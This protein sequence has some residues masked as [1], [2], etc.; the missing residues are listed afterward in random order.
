MAFGVL[1]L[2]KTKNLIIKKKRTHFLK[3]THKR[4]F[5]FGIHR[6]GIGPMLRQRSGDVDSR[7]V[8]EHP[9]KQPQHWS[10]QLGGSLPT[11]GNFSPLRRIEDSADDE[12]TTSGK[13][14]STLH[15]YHLIIISFFQKLNI[16]WRINFF[17]QKLMN[18][19][20]LCNFPA[21]LRESPL[22]NQ[23]NLSAQK[24]FY[25]CRFTDRQFLCCLNGVFSAGK[26]NSTKVLP[27]KLCT[28]CSCWRRIIIRKRERSEENNK[29]PIF[30]LLNWLIFIGKKWIEKAS[31]C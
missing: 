27:T 4:R 26:W 28:Q 14:A 11:R 12:R 24:K 7:L 10:P 13:R 31:F 15:L 20:L 22:L 18:S 21:C 30:I 1:I 16:L 19:S 3:I 23:I 17:F 2:S 9:T 29:N 5:S 8:F 25:F 6:L